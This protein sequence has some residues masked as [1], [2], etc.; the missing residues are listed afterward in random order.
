[1]CC[2]LKSYGKRIQEFKER[3]KMVR[4]Y[5][6]AA[7]NYLDA[8]PTSKTG[9]NYSDACEWFARDVFFS[10]SREWDDANGGMFGKPDW[11]AF[12]ER[13]FGIDLTL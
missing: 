4:A 7:Q 11:K 9:V 6:R 10:S 1:M 13:K 3:P 12:L 2:P 8:H 5:I